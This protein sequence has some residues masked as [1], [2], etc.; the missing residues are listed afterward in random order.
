M[1]K[2]NQK[3]FGAVEGLLIFVVLA[4]IGGAGF[5]VYRQVS[6]DETDKPLNDTSQKIEKTSEDTSENKTVS[7]EAFTKELMG[8]I[9]KGDNTKL[10]TYL[11]D[12]YQQ[13]RN[14]EMQKMVKDSPQCR[15]NYNCN[16]GVDSSVL[17]LNASSLL[18][19]PIPLSVKTPTITDYTFKNGQ[20]GKSV[21]YKEV[22]ETGD[23][24]TTYFVFNIVPSSNSWQLNDYVDIFVDVSSGQKL[25]S[26]K[27]LR[28]L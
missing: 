15:L 24:G 7:P 12:G 8:I 25:P 1:N 23:A 22:Q 14:K 11:T 17:A 26:N 3:G 2:L 27:G 4:L 16:A 20:K 13:F 10:Q 28:E 5:Y 18:T 9:N 19:D 6:N 21:V